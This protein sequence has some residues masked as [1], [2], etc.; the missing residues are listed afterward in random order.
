MSDNSNFFFVLINGRKIDQYTHQN[1]TFVEGRKGSEY[2]LYFQNSS[3][4]RKKVVFSVDGLNILSG[5]KNWES[6]YVI[7]PWQTAIIPGWRKDSGNVAKFLFSS[8]DSSY[9][10]HNDSGDKG[11]IGVI[12]AMVFEEKQY[13]KSV[14]TYTP[15]YNFH[16]HY[17]NCWQPSQTPYYP[18]GVRTFNVNNTAGVF[19]SSI[20]CSFN[21]GSPLISTK[22]I[23]YSSVIG[24][25][26]EDGPLGTGWGENK[27]FET[28]EVSYEFLSSPAATM[29]IYYDSRSNLIRRGINVKEP[30]YNP[31]E[32]QAF[33]GYRDGCPTPK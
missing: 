12:G 29:M 15:N 14:Y 30:N 7:N 13:P 31:P 8:V 16:Y 33:P 23:D 28:K 9:N 5:D 27:T 6:G 1:K 20:A 24:S 2:T 26:V 22:E 18:P 17:D 3:S 32:P 21:E 4:T 10:Q 19:G 11:N 25:K